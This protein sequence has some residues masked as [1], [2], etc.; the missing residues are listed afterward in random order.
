[1][2]GSASRVYGVGDLVLFLVVQHSSSV[3]QG[4]EGRVVAPGSRGEVGYRSALCVPCQQSDV[5]M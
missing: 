3:F 2:T 4:S 5:C 1:M